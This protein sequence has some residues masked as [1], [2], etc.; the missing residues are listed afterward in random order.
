MSQVSFESAR[1]RLSWRTSDRVL[2]TGASGW[3]GKTLTELIPQSVPTLLLAGKPRGSYRAWNAEEIR[4]F[5]PTL[6]FHFAFDRRQVCQ[7]PVDGAD[8]V[9][10]ETFRQ[11]EWMLGLRGVRAVLATSSG[12]A[13]Q[14]PRREKEIYGEWKKKEEQ[15]ALGGVTSTRNVIV[16]RP[17]SLSGP[18][19]TK[20][21]D[22]AFSDLILQSRTGKMEIK[23]RQLTYRRYC[24]ASDYLLVCTNQMLQGISA[25]IDSGGPLVEM[26]ELAEAVRVAL[27]PGCEI[28]RDLDLDA[29][30]SWYA[31]DDLSWQLHHRAVGLN[32]MNIEQQVR[33][34]ASLLE[35]FPGDP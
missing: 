27:N 24:S 31:S 14:A 18:H 20:P 35:A 23:A 13:L 12:A 1:A 25:C 16:A 15:I 30:V 8:D 28:V 17:W 10:P 11:L 34:C 22:Y 2:V 3:L 5:A 19:V 21:R 6:I 26:Q 29:A 9:E 7:I 4:D 32:T 33:A